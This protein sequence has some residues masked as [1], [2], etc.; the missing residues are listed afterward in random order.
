MNGKEASE[1]ARYYVHI[2]AASDGDHQVH[3]FDC[4]W[5]PAEENRK[6]LGDFASC[7]PAVTEAKKHF[8]KVNGCIHCSRECHR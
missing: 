2:R 8:T 5:L 4:S 1:M 6:Y 3:R 7:Q